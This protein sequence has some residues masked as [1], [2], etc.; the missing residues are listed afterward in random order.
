MA[1][2][3][4]PAERCSCRNTNCVE[5]PLRR[6]FEG[7]AS[8]VAACPWPFLL[9]PLLLSGGL[10]AGFVFLPQRRANDIEGQFTPTWGPAKAERDFVRRHFPTDDSQRFSGPRLPSEGAYAALI[11]VATNGTSVL[12]AAA[13]AEV[14]RLNATVHDAEYER[15]CARTAGGCASPNELLSRRGDAGPPAPGSLRFPVNDGV[16]LG[17]ALGGVETDGGRVLGARALKLVYYL[18]EDGPE[19]QDSRQWLESFLQHIP[20]KVAELR[21][22]SIQVTYFTSLSRQQEFEGN[23]KS[24]IP[25][26]SITYFLTI[27]FSIVSCLRRSCIRNNIWLASCG[28][29]SSGLAVLSS[30]GLMLFC[31]VPFVITV[32]NAPFLILGVGVDDM[33]IMIASWEQSSRKKEKSSV[34]S[35]LA[36]TYAEAALSVTITTLTDVLA[37]FIGTWTAFPS[38]RSFCLYTGTAFVF[39]YVYTM[40]FFGAVLV[41]NHKR[42]QGN[43][44]WLTCMRVDV[45]KDQAENSCLY[46]ACCIGSCS[47]QPSQPEGEHPMNVFFKKYYGPFVTN[48]WIKALMVLLYGAY[49][50]GS[51]YG[52]TQIREGIDLRNLANDA[53]YVIPYYDD[54]DEY[55]STYGPRVM[56]VITESVDY[57]NESV[58]LGIESCAQNLENISYVDKNLSE[59]WLRVYTELDRRGLININSKTDFLNNLTVLFRVRPSFEWDINKTQD[60]IEASR[61]FIQTAN[62]TSAVD[63]KNL[64]NELREAAKQC[65][66]PLMV[67]HPAFIYYDQYLVI[68][69]NTVQNV[70]VAAGAMLVV[71]LLL[72][73]NPLCCLWVT[74]A[75]ASVIVGVAGFMTFWN[76]NL[77]SISMINLVICIGFSV[78]F[79]AHISYAFV[80]SGESS[81]NKRA[82]EALSLLGYPVLQGA[83]STILGVVV[84]A[85]ANTYIFRTFFKIMFLVILFGA[86]HGLV[87]I[88]VFLTFFGN[89]GSSP[90]NTESKKLEHRFRN[91]KDCP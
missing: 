45:D 54:N 42:E 39:C 58:R 59:S 15:L 9:V 35:L 37:F 89:F 77:D 43:R 53:S 25:L 86:L 73:P 57:W 83:V 28:V 50:G 5:R 71:S 14:L 22:G 32:A 11:A 84:L 81:A 80:T 16:F 56:V 76:V 19:A 41:L 61:F 40:T 34:K 82:I 70:V 18:R 1:G 55:F 10:G 21:L 78:D 88:P 60:E 51:V 67:Y 47:R 68:V 38:V 66:I 4:D 27:N 6:L 2:P 52:C 85:A 72:I 91:D 33:F 74:F 12:D 87:F 75:I 24:V 3:R 36:E 29:L 63:E 13:W 62:V 69:Q 90:H 44:H 8:G 49:L 46:N 26:F 65:S 20:S 31:G 79:S 48:K 17:A 23:T 64:L 7:L 30:F